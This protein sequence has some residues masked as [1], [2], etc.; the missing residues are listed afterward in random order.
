V[1]Q[2]PDRNF[3]DDAVVDQD[4]DRNSE[5]DLDSEDLNFDH[6]IN[7]VKAELTENVLD[8]PGAIGGTQTADVESDSDSVSDEM[9]QFDPQNHLY[10]P[11]RDTT[12]PSSIVEKKAMVPDLSVVRRQVKKTLTK[13]QKVRH[14]PPPQGGSGKIRKEHSKKKQVSDFMF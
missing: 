3:E 4:P 2:D 8:T 14:K 11:H 13:K 7:D 6:S 5:D 1:D 12:Q 10:R 9:E